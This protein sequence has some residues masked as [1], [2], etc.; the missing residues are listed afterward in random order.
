MK[1]SDCRFDATG[2]IVCTYRGLPFQ[3]SEAETPDEWRELQGLIEA[4]EVIV[5]AYVPP[6]KPTK[7][8]LT[9]QAEAAGRARRDAELAETDFVVNRHRDQEEMGIETTLSD[10]EYRGW[11]QYRQ[12]L[13]DITEQE[14]WP[15]SVVWPAE[16]PPTQ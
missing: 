4:G 6:P 11:L 15:L 1:F 16:P 9:A 10:E 5:E 7:K 14:G 2:A 12:S 3:A 13:R 8:E